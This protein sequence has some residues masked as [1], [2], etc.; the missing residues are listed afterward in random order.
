MAERLQAELASLM[1]EARRR[2]EQSGRGTWRQMQEE[3]ESS[4]RMRRR[5]LTRRR[6]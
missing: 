3:L 6:S 4:A 2:K 5:M 1:D